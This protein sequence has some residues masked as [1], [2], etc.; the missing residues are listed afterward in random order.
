MKMRKTMITALVLGACMSTQLF[1]QVKQ[2]TITFALTGQQQVSVSQT[3]ANNAGYWIQP[4]SVN[5]AEQG[6]KYYKTQT[7]KL[8]EKNILQFIAYVRHGNANYYSSKATLVLVQ[9][10]LSGFFNITPDL[11]N[12]LANIVAHSGQNGPDGTFTP[13]ADYNTSLPNATDS[14]FVTLANGRHLQLN[15]DGPVLNPGTDYYPVGH[16][17][18]WGQI[19]V[20]DTAGAG[21]VASPV[22]DNVTYFFALSVQECYDCFYM[23][24]FVSDATFKT[25]KSQGGG[26]V[27]CNAG[28]TLQGTG[29]D[30]YYLTLS[31]DNTQNNPYLY[32]YDNAY[33]G[34]QGIAASNKGGIPGD[35]ISPDVIPYHSSIAAAITKNIPYE[36]RFTL[37]GIM[38]YTWKLAYVNKSDVLPDFI[39]TGSYSA[40]GYG[41]IGLFCQL[42]NGTATFSERAVKT[43]CCTDDT[44]FNGWADNWYGVGAEYEA[45]TTSGGVGGLGFDTV[46]D[47]SYGV[48]TPGVGF[49]APLPTPLNVGT[50]L[51]YH[52]NFDAT[53]PWNS[54]NFASGWLTPSI[55][56]SWFT[57]GAIPSP[58]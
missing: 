38:T 49:G 41:F 58:L 16:M 12:S 47:V 22:C 43:A 9:G 55:V 42:L 19:Y 4:D 51:T 29:K 5:G 40:S 33:V 54:N 46:W 11:A 8:T 52:E 20:Q 37:N 15:P 53:Y 31:F 3:T 35:A 10:E 14:T 7:V 26:P 1:A 28:A 17:Q 36:A 44:T 23:N 21:S 30:R 2:D 39:G 24:S 18:P 48:Y 45:T 13:N 34:V 57:Q 6:P 56:F 25:V 32:P 27:C 50:S